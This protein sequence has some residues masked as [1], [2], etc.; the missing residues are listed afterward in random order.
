MMLP[1]VSY[2]RVQ[3]SRGLEDRHATGN[4]VVRAR[5]GMIEVA[6]VVDDLVLLVRT[7]DLRRNELVIPFLVARLDPGVEQNLLAGSEPLLQLSR[8]TE[9]D[10]EAERLRL[11]ET[12]DVPPANQPVVFLPPGT[13]LVRGVRDDPG[14]A[15]LANRE[16]DDRAW[17]ARR[18]HKLAGDVLA[19]VIRLR[20]ARTDVDERRGDIG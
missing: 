11:R 4:V 19:P 2:Q 5:P 1:S 12:A 20:R 13:P 9:R 3:R 10:H 17:L 15:F 6:G 14:C 7:L 16:I 8:F 18:E